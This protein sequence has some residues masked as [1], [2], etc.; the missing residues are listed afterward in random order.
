MKIIKTHTVD[1]SVV[2]A[3]IQQR[4]HSKPNIEYFPAIQPGSNFIKINLREVL[5]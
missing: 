3:D 2:S 4:K 1:N 5:T